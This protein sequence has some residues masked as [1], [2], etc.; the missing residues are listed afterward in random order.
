[1]RDRNKPGSKDKVKNTEILSRKLDKKI[2]NQPNFTHRNEPGSRAFRHSA[3]RLN[4]TIK[5]G[6][7]YATARKKGTT[8]YSIGTRV[9]QET[10]TIGIAGTTEK[11]LANDLARN[12]PPPRAALSPGNKS[13]AAPFLLSGI[14]KFPRAISPCNRAEKQRS[15]RRR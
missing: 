15:G 4:G 14:I 5:A 12:S 6:P 7:G 10:I 8:R 13:F 3:W 1:M 9:S 2:F 11:N